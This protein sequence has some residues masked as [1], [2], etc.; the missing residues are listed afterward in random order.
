MAAGPQK[1]L[2]VSIGVA[3]GQPAE[4]HISEAMLVEAAE[5]ALYRARRRGQNLCGVGRNR[6]GF[7][8]DAAQ[9]LN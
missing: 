7:A 5:V 1:L 6:A 8:D 2:S 3:D 9:E 4:R